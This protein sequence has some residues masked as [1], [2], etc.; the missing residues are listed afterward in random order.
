M[1]TMANGPNLHL[2]LSRVDQDKRNVVDIVII[3][4]LSTEE[5]IV[6]VYQKKQQNVTLSIVQVIM[7]FLW[8]SSEHRICSARFSN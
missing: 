1:A 5:W 6:L 7:A 4:L 2:V 8:V 3:L